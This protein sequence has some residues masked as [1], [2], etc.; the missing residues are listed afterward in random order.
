MKNLPVFSVPHQ[1]QPARVM[2]SSPSA[3]NPSKQKANIAFE[4]HPRADA[5]RSKLIYIFYLIDHL[6]G[7]SQVVPRHNVRDF[8]DHKKLKKLMLTDHHQLVRFNVVPIRNIMV[9]P[10]QRWRNRIQVRCSRWPPVAMWASAVL[11][12]KAFKGF[13]IFLIFLNMLVLMISS[14]ID[15]QVVRMKMAVEVII[16]VIILIFLAEIGLHWA[17]S[18]QKYWESPWNIFD[19]T[20]TIISFIPELIYLA[21]KTSSVAVVRLLQV[22]RVLRCLKLFPRVRQVRV[23]IM[24]IAKALKAMAFILVLLLFFFYVFAVSGIFFFESY[25]RSDRKDLKYNMYFTDMP[26]ALVTIFILFTMDHW[27]A[28]L[29]DTWKVPEI[30]KVISGFFVCLWLLI[31]AFIFRNLF[32]A[33]M[34]TNFQNIRSDLSEEVK[35]IETQQQ[36]DKFKMELLEKRYSMPQAHM[37]RVST[38]QDKMSMGTSSVVPSTDYSSQEFHA[39]PLD[40]ETYIHKNLPGLYEADDDEQVIWP[41]DSLFRYFE[42]LEKLQYNLDERKQ[43]QH[44]AVLALSNLEDK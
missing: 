20:V 6:R 5:I 9:T 44:Y 13:L 25:S 10:E 27:Y 41:R 12:S 16:W 21:D 11:N 37:D 15:N 22:C 14:E 35:Q 8:L 7:L 19:F 40:W 26:N 34:V 33:I 42:L 39:G 3:A 30:N 18:F 4:V 38:T 32:V 23:L 43:L 31:G 24:A 36:A 17:V 1:E 28:L 2:Q 29:Q